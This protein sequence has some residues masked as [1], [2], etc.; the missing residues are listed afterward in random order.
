MTVI[1]VNDNAT[2][3]WAAR[4]GSELVLVGPGAEEGS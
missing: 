3:V 4:V 2:G 1:I